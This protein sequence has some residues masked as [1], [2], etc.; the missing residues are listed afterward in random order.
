MSDALHS[1]RPRTAKLPFH[2]GR[3]DLSDETEVA[4]LMEVIGDAELPPV[5]ESAAEPFVGITTDGM[6]VPDL[7]HLADE[8]LDGKRLVRAAEGYL[9]G[10]RP[11]QLTA[12]VLPLDAPEWR[13][14]I[15]AFLTFP[16]H[17][18]LLDDLAE[19]Q[20]RAALDVIAASMSGAGFRNVRAA[21]RLNAEL[22][23]ICPG[24]EDTLREFKY[25]F[26]I[27]GTPSVT[28]PWGWQ[29]LGHHLDL[30]CLVVGNQ[31][32]MTPTFLGTEFDGHTL[33][34][35]HYRAAAELLGSLTST[36]RRQAVLYPSISSTDLPWE[37]GGAID[38]RHRAG[39][40][41]DNRVIPYEG[42]KGD[43]L[44]LGQREL[45]L[46]VAR[47]YLAALPPGPFEA[48]RAQVQRHIEETRFAWIGGSDPGE[49]C[50]YRMHGPV[51]LV[52]YDNHSGIF[53]DNPE[54][55][56]Y[57]VHTIVRTPN[58]N[59]YGRDLLRSHHQRHHHV[60]AE[61]G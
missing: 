26:T 49:A 47:P 35:E 15:N 61:T 29:L 56:P 22:G 19:P 6:T 11:E 24:Y 27:F 46:A 34:A 1:A 2:N 28:E 50:Y 33:F 39:A 38:G 13:L 60:S 53:L 25:W 58:G 30:H 40:G 57:H 48:K 31:L 8:G 43:A 16:E 14:W 10:L 42:I 55:E 3:V 12:A 52:E 32:V 41:R 23:D 45:L 59:D 51:L 5:V 7:F 20:R 54:P 17:G 18:L 36:Q 44:S 9:E 21:M 37:L 4:N